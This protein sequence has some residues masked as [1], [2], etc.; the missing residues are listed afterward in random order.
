METKPVIPVFFSVDDA[1][2]PFLAVALNSIRSNASSRYAYRIHILS[3]DLSRSNRK[4]LSRFAGEG[5]EILFVPLT[6]RLRRFG[7]ASRLRNHRFSA[8]SSLTIYFRLFIPELFP[9]YDKAI[10]LDSDIV[11]PGDLSRLWEEPLGD[12]LVGACADYST[13]HIPQFTRYIDAYVGVDHRNYVN[14]GVLLMNLDRLRKEDMAG[15]FLSWMEKYHFATVAP[16]QDYLN[17]LCNGSIHYLDPSWDTMPAE[18]APVIRCPQIIHFNLATK[19][20]L[21]E[22]VQYEDVFWEYALSSGYE[23]EIRARR[24]AFLR[25]PGKRARYEE[26]IAG[27]VRLAGELTERQDS[28]RYI[29]SSRRE[30]RLCCC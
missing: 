3:D 5:F 6:R 28:F 13:L 29:I 19:P 7:V 16:D 2:A 23:R 10:Y 18:C 26:G 20:W 12:C 21:C 9:Q 15:R 1:Y 25:D 14:S 11:V 17:A 4:R 30:F 8:F 27:L 22:S 24:E